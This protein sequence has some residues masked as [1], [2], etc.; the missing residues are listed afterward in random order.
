MSASEVQAAQN[1]YELA[2]ERYRLLA[3][4]LEKEDS[5]IIRHKPTKA[6]PVVIPATRVL[7]SALNL[8]MSELSEE[9]LREQVVETAVATVAESQADGITEGDPA[10]QASIEQTTIGHIPSL[11]SEEPCM[12]PFFHSTARI[13]T[14]L[15][16]HRQHAC[17]DTA[18]RLACPHLES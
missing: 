6:A 3:S 9:G 12:F 18:E 16:S 7:P 8:D 4:S 14:M 1:D 17:S 15:G 11:L 10:K 13:L 5:V 2:R